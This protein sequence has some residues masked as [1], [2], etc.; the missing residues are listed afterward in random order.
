MNKNEKAIQIEHRNGNRNGN[1][2]KSKDDIKI[3]IDM[4]KQH[5][6]K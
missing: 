6:I 1:T 4:K 3:Q 5:K 2:N